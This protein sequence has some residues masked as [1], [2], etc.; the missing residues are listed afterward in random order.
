MT[1]AESPDPRAPVDDTPKSNGQDLPDA[2]REPSPAA[3]PHDERPAE[4]AFLKGCGT[5]ALILF[6]VVG[7]LFGSCF[8][9]VR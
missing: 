1:P 2:W 5:V 9:L 8:L 4:T 6:A 3:P 7:L